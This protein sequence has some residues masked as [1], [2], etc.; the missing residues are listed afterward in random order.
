M[1]SGWHEPDDA[2]LD[3]LLR[4]SL[5]A[6]ADR[7]EPAG[8]GLRLIRERTA[9]DR[10]WSRWRVPALVLAGAA[11]VVAALVAA[12]SVLPSLPPSSQSAA[13]PSGP[14]SGPTPIPGAGVNDLLTV[15]PYPNRA[16]GFRQAGADQTAGTYGDLTRPDQVAMR[17]IGSYVGAR[18]LSVVSA[19]AYQAGLRMEVRWRGRPVSLVYVVRVRVGDDAP[20]VVVDAVA[21][22]GNLTVDRTAT[23]P[24]SGLLTVHGTVR[25]T[26]AAGAAPRVQLRTPGRTL[27][28]SATAATVHGDR[29]SAALSLPDGTRAA[30]MTAWTVDPGGVAAFV[31]RPLG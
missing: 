23:V 30:A 18:S 27:V 7:I 4:R 10:G 26:V 14:A 25:G 28:L 24:S 13:Q 1:S 17:F 8:D 31:S 22:D 3:A 9:P 6:E 19:G 5:S 12:P 29:W 2:E 21:P 15:W 11:A 16:E 20:Y